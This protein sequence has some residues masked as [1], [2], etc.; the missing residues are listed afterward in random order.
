MNNSEHNNSP[1]KYLIGSVEFLLAI[2]MMLIILLLSPTVVI[3]LNLFKN[4]NYIL[5]L[6]FLYLLIILLLS[7]KTISTGFSFRDDSAD[8][9]IILCKIIKYLKWMLISI[10]L[11]FL[12]LLSMY[13][14]P[15]E[16]SW[17]L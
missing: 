9:E 14:I 17:H 8:H 7:L 1:G 12:F 10:S 3:I 4:F 11:L 6:S 5:F 16:S 15:M 13:I 2:L